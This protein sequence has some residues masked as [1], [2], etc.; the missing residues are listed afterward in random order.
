VDDPLYILLIIL[1]ICM[2]VYLIRRF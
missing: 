1:V 2:I